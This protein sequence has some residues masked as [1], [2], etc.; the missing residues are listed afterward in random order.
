MLLPVLTGAAH[1]PSQPSQQ[2]HEAGAEAAVKCYQSPQL[3]FW[4]CSSASCGQAPTEGCHIHQGP[5]KCASTE[6]E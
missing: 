4:L 1:S 2:P 3:P 5:E 6:G